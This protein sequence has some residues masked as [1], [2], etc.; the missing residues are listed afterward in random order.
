MARRSKSDGGDGCCGCLFIILVF[1]V[2]CVGSC[3]KQKFAERAQIAQERAEKEAARRQEEADKEA[4]RRREE[5]AARIKAEEEARELAAKEEAEK[6]MLQRED[7]LRSFTLKEAPKLWTAYQTLKAG[8]AN[9]NS[10]IDELRKTLVDF[11]Q[12]PDVDADFK[13]ICSIR[14][15]MVGSL[16]SLHTKIVDAY[17]VA[18]TYEAAPGQK[19]Y[20]QL[21]RKLEDG[22]QEAEAAVQKYNDM[23]ETK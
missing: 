17:L 5:E 11:G 7:K 21:R 10:K 16:K 9:Q 8:I 18:R 6:R 23:K 2:L 20:D 13:R 1:A 3:I 14:D 22:T 4:A 12:D 15:E 19:E